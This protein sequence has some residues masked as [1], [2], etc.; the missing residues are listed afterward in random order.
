MGNKV[1]VHVRSFSGAK[2]RCMEDYCKPCV[3]EN[4]PDHIILH[5]GTNEL[6]FEKSAEMCGK[7]IMDLAKSLITDKRTVSVSGIIPRNDEWNNK[8]SEV[9]N[10]LKRMC[11]ESGMAFIDYVQHINPRKHLNRSKL[12]LNEKGAFKLDCVLSDYIYNFLK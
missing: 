3:R 6:N 1:N 10:Y 4:D 8:G 11:E 12:H 2:V 9:N 7:E 5:V